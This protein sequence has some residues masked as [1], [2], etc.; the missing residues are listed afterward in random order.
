MK[1]SADT[2]K[3][4]T[5]DNTE[6]YNVAVTQEVSLEGI[7]TEGDPFE[8]AMKKKIRNKEFVKSYEVDTRTKEAEYGMYMISAFDREYTH[9]EFATYSLTGS[10]NGDAVEET[11]TEIPEGAPT[12]EQ[13][14][15]GGGGV[16]G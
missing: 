13:D 11:L 10:L 3:L 5:N 1:I 16:E 8:K 2:L 14:D 15:D 4:S 12:S 6:S 7:L 9:G